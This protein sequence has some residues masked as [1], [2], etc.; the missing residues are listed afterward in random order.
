MIELVSR[1]SVFHK[2]P[3]T[4]NEIHLIQKSLY[5]DNF[6]DTNYPLT[7]KQIIELELEFDFIEAKPV[8]YY[9]FELIRIKSKRY[10]KNGNIKYHRNIA[11]DLYDLL[12]E[13]KTKNFYIITHLK[14]DFFNAMKVHYKVKRYRKTYSKLEEK[15]KIGSYNE[16]LK[17]SKDELIDF[18]EIF[19]IVDTFGGGVPEYIL[20]CDENDNFCFFFHY[21]G[22][23]DFWSF[24]ENNFLSDSV[25][26]KYDFIKI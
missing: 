7:E 10:S 17:I 3:K 26:N 13:T 15:I 8:E 21:S 12:L 25:L 23:I 14:M 9:D 22:Q 16:A 6:S 11:N 24:N 19:N 20:I 4:G 2:L 18:L 5:D 1:K